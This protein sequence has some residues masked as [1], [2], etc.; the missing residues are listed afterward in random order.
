MDS[1]YLFDRICESCEACGRNTPKHIVDDMLK[2][3]PDSIWENPKARVLDA[4]CKSRVFLDACFKKFK[5]A[6]G[7]PDEYIWENMLYG[8]CISDAMCFVMRY[9]LPELKNV[10]VWHKVKLGDMKFD[11]VVGNP[12]YNKDAYIDFV[13]KGHQLA[14]K[15]SLWIT[16]A[17]WQA[18]GSDER[19]KTFRSDI[20][21]CISKIVSYKLSYDV[22]D[23]S[24]PGVCYYLVDKQPCQH[25]LCCVSKTCS[26]F[27]SDYEL[28][29]DSNLVL[30]PDKLLSIINICS[31]HPLVDRL[32]FSFSKYIGN[33]DRGYDECTSDTD[34]QVVQGGK[35]CGFIPYDSLRSTDRIDKY[36]CY[37]NVI[38][39]SASFLG[40]D[41]RALG[42]NVVHIAMPYQVPKGSFTC[43]MYFD[44]LDDAESFV[45]YCST[46]LVRFLHFLG[47]CGTAIVPSFWRFVPDPEK[48]DHIYTDEELYTKYNLS[49]EQI[50]V[51][52]SVIKNR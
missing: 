11:L 46:K 12:P 6:L 25:W 15:H 28:R 7:L 30:I 51:V 19:N 41:G 27:C 47:I 18:K 52:E 29:D 44:T 37:T 42:M 23:I 4:N 39:G 33:T 17:K 14:T 31:G 40:D 45:S 1:G 13:L 34:L 5:A 9:D 50:Q 22:F 8:A 36:K 16:P 21:S 43:L 24:E 10:G 20:A 38:V 48:F 26:H 49:E 2:L 35:V 3:V 32:E